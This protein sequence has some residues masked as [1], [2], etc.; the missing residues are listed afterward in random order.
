VYNRDLRA[1]SEESAIIFKW[2]RGFDAGR[3]F[4]ARSFRS[5]HLLIDWA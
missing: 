2:L 4:A 3:L 1:L 5:G